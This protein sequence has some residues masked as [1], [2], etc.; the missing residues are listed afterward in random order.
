MRCRT[1]PTGGLRGDAAHQGFADGAA[2][3]QDGPQRD[4]SVLAWPIKRVV[5]AHDQLL[6]AGVA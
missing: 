1:R 4:A 2:D 6:T 3:Q 5:I